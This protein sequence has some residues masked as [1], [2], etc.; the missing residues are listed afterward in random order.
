MTRAATARVRSR[1]ARTPSLR[2]RVT[3]AATAATVVIVAIVGAVA[4][5]QVH[6]SA[7]RE[8]DA[9]V[10][11]LSA[12][13][14]PSISNPNATT[15]ATGVAAGALATIRLGTLS[16]AST[17]PPVPSQ[18][19]G[20][21]DQTINGT[22]YRVKTVSVLDSTVLNGL[23][24]VSVAIP[25][26]D[27]ENR[28]DD[29][30]R[31]LLFIAAGAVVA[32]AVLAWLLGGLAVR[33]LRRLARQTAAI[34]V[35]AGPESPERTALQS[36]RGAREAEDLAEAMD[37]LLHRVDDERTRTQE[38]LAT[39]RDFASVSAHELRTPLTAMRTD[40]EVLDTFAPDAAARAEIVGD[41][42]RAH[43]RI[44]ET[45]AALES[46]AQGELGGRH[47]ETLDVVDLL[48]R[49]VT[50]ASARHPGVRISL[51]GAR[52]VIAPVVETGLR[53][54]VDNAV[55][56]AIR[57]GEATEVVVAAH[58][59]P[60][61]AAVV[62]DDNGRGIPVADRDRLFRRFERGTS[63]HS[64]SGLGLALIAQQAA[65]HHGTATLT[66]SPSGGTR[67]T[68]TIGA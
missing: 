52:S 25:L 15:V 56:N 29:Q 32:A 20:V 41:L 8:L 40:L 64:G 47:R 28:I 9:R 51:A 11:T 60:T 63:K 19:V 54:A 33:P 26:R 23:A 43:A 21:R 59:A 45:L 13:M 2:T 66:D 37:A 36:V 65:L 3:L 62:V 50:E 68:I 6:T 12:A 53:M 1:R 7:Y 4:W 10:D 22:D 48:D 5:T 17:T 39:A 49:V 57:H 16:V 27:T 24:T 18:S 58:P 61:G 55:L 38:A 14:Q 67:L 46:L 35:D 42:R 44:Q 34:G 31:A 30:R